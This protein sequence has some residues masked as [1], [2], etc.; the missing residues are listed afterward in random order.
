MEKAENEK[1]LFR[2]CVWF[3]SG[4][5]NLQKRVETWHQSPPKSS[6]DGTQGHKNGAKMV[7][8]WSQKPSKMGAVRWGTPLP[9]GEDG[10]KV[11]KTKKRTKKEGCFPQRPTILAEIWP[12]LSSQNGA[13][14]AKNS[15][16]KSVFFDASWDVFCCFCE[17]WLF[18]GGKTEPSWH[19]HGIKNRC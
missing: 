5:Q 2:T 15:M 18:L 1:P 16:Q 13:K 19:Q 4:R 11:R 8:T 6:A 3:N 12:Q 14:M 7:P 17:F 10:E 9:R